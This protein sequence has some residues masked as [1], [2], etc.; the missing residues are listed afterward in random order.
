[1]NRSKFKFLVPIVLFWLPFVAE[2]APGLSVTGITVTPQNAP[3]VV[4]ALD[5]WMAS[6]VGKQYKGRLLLQAHVADGTDPATHSIVALHHSAAEADAFATLAQNDPAWAELLNTIVPISQQQ[7]TGRA[8]TI[9]SWGDI[10]DTDTVWNVH[11]FTITDLP[12]V[13]AALDT[14]MASPMGKK[15]PGQIHLSAMSAVGINPATH[16]ISVGYASIAEMET[17]GDMAAKDPDW[18][19][20]LT[21][22]QKAS[23]HLGAVIARDVKSWGPATMKSL[24]QQ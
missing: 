16:V 6:P 17:Y 7:F 2:A 1:M 21:A 18:A 4:A 9:K 15:A 14:W 19:K 5:K 13:M 12:A 3:K 11:Y 8:T 20:F 10:N 22:M 24:T 23:T